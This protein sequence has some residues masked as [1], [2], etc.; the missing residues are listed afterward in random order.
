M[1]EIIFLK[2]LL[3]ELGF[4][5][6]QANTIYN[7][8]CIKICYNTE[9]H[10]RSKHIHVR[11]CFVQEKVERHEFTVTYCGTKSMIADIFTKA[12]DKHQFRELRAKLR[13]Q[14]LENRSG[15]SVK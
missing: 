11:Y 9:L 4:T 1:Q 15:H 5:A 2:L 12:L 8:S 10:G 6:T 7:Q 14:S 13:M 3:Q